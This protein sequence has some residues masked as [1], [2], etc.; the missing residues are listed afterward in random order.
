[1]L[2]SHSRPV[3]IAISVALFVSGC[4]TYSP[5]PARIAPGPTTVR[6]SLTDAA[7]SETIG[8]L[9]SQ[10]VSLEGQVR[11]VGDSTIAVAVTEIGRVGADDQSVPGQLVSV[12]VR[13]I[14]R[15]ERKKTLVGRSLL[16]AAAVTGAAVWVGLQA[17]HGSVS[18]RRPTTPPPP[19]Q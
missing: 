6:L 10:I 4:A 1:M 16:L 13:W 5:L 14:Y 8:S 17:G 15:V 12:P 9:G 2:L 19:G 7:R 18:A 11:S 3:A